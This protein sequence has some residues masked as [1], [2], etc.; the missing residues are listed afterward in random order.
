MK[1]KLREDKI[2]KLE[3][4]HQISPS[5]ETAMLQEEVSL[6]KQQ[7]E[8]EQNDNTNPKVIKLVSEVSQLQER[9][10]NLET[11]LNP[12]LFPESIHKQL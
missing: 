10:R 2:Q 12:S 8:Q 4:E 1:I 9:V 11:E 3:N 6:L 7:L 5:E